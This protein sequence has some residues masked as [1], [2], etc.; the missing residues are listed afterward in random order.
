MGTF[1]SRPSAWSCSFEASSPGSSRRPSDTTTIACGRSSADAPSARS[2]VV[3]I[4]AR[5]IRGLR[6]CFARLR[7]ERVAERRRR[8]ARTWSARLLRL[9]R[10]LADGSVAHGRARARAVLRQRHRARRVGEH[11]DLRADHALACRD[12]HRPRDRRE[13]GEHRDE[14]GRRRSR[15]AALAPSQLE[16]EEDAQARARRARKRA[17]SPRAGDRR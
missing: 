13:Q 11:D 16:D 6:A 14:P 17:P 2:A 7:P 4:A 15:P 12:A 9:L 3:E 1:R 5:R 10:D 8:S